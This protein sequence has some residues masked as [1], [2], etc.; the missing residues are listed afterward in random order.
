MRNPSTETVVL[1]DSPPTETEANTLD[2]GTS[3]LRYVPMAA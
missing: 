2:D 1:D 3:G